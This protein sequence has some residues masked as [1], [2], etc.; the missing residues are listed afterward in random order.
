VGEWSTTMPPT[1]ADQ[2][3]SKMQ[4][5]EQQL[6]TT[7]S[8]TSNTL[9][10]WTLYDATSVVG[11]WTNWSTI[12]PASATGRTIENQYISPTYKTQ[13]NYWGYRDASNR[14]HF[15]AGCGKYV[16]GTKFS[17]IESGWRDTTLSYTAIN[18]RCIGTYSDC[19]HTGMIYCYTRYDSSSPNF[20]WY[21]TR[22]VQT[23]GGYYEYRYRDT[24]Y[25]YYFYKYSDWS[26][27]KDRDAGTPAE[28]LSDMPLRDTE[29]RTLAVPVPQT[30]TET[31]T[32]YQ[33]RNKVIQGDPT[34][35]TEDTTGTTYL[36]SGTLDSLAVDYSG[37]K[38]TVL[39]YQ[40][41]NTDPTAGQLQYVDQ[42]E[43][44]DGNTYSFDFKPKEDPSANT[45][46]FIVALALEGATRIINVDI[47]E[48][49]KPEYT[50]KFVADGVELSSQTVTEGGT[51]II[52][53]IPQKEGH[54]FIGW[55]DYTTN[56][57][58]NL[59]I[60][61][62][63]IKNHYV[64]ALVDFAN[65]TVEMNLYT[66]GDA[67]GTLPTPQAEGKIF[68]GWYTLVE[69]VKQAVSADDI[70][71]GN[72]L[73][74]ADWETVKYTVT[75]VDQDDNEVSTQIVAYGAAAIP[76]G[77]ISSDDLVFAGWSTDVAWWKVT[78][79][80]T[81]P[82]IFQYARTVEGPNVSFDDDIVDVIILKSSTPGATIY[83]NVESLASI[84][85]SSVYAGGET[86]CDF[87]L[88]SVNGS[89][90]D[91]DNDAHDLYADDELMLPIGFTGIYSDEEPIVITEDI[92][93]TAMAVKD[94]MN[95]S[96]TVVVDVLY[97][98]PNAVD[99]PDS[100]VAMVFAE[101]ITAQ[102]GDIIDIPVYIS[103]LVGIDSMQLSLNYD[104]DVL[105]R[106]SQPAGGS[107]EIANVSRLLSIAEDDDDGDNIL[108]TTLRFEV[109][110]DVEPGDYQI[111]ITPIAKDAD[112]NTIPIDITSAFVIVVPDG[113][114]YI[115]SGVVKSYNPSVATA[116]SLL[117]DGEYKYITAI[118]AT[119]E[120]GQKEQA[121]AFEGV[122]A[123]VYTLEITKDAHTIFI[124]NNIVVDDDH[125][126]LTRHVNSAVSVMTLLCGDINGDGEIN[127]ADLNLLW[128]PTN[129]NKRVSEGADP[130]CDLNGDGEVNQLDLNILW[131]LINYNKGAVVINLP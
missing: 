119:T 66:Y 71:T 51:A 105:T 25:T 67:I 49:P 111:M 112:G 84:A 8:T 95:V 72:T 50:V 47:I 121:F 130:S 125:V 74:I 24:S 57:Y 43:I 16:Y 100:Y 27:W 98:D 115:V 99:T 36:S 87:W 128:Q 131:Q 20:Y 81:V 109:N 28:I 117:Q 110:S 12:S 55:N 129:Y 90:Y 56:I 2:T 118:Q 82:P 9:S 80:L 88:N 29:I 58:S 44:K 23:G 6:Q 85:D 45:G 39:V 94:G 89:C 78:S 19:W 76:P 32:L 68:K 107:L 123:G 10:G 122:Y 3:R 104:R 18:Q 124:V 1:S 101:D 69:N 96:E 22:T 106:I 37:H 126:D 63:Y 75:F 93:L 60:T 11:D 4:I 52:P 54:T 42:I 35:G 17:Y 79:N 41:T 113:D 83:Y 48:A 77:S 108:L 73:I 34:A 59:V 92:R 40:R 102:P 5:R 14:T 33:Y 61:A 65:D 31:R 62:N 53:A 114:V 64:V 70:V 30:Q 97:V 103:D 127:Q 15:C 7:T 120:T 46:D 38:A 91:D 26:E 13:Y 21:N 86:E 116:L